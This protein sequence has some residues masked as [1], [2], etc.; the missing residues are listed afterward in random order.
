MLMPVVQ[1]VFGWSEKYAKNDESK[2]SLEVE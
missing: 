2:T 1:T